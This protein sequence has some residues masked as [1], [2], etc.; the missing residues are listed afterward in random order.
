MTVSSPILHSKVLALV[1]DIILPICSLLPFLHHRTLDQKFA[2]LRRGPH[3]PYNTN[4]EA[5][6]DGAI[7]MAYG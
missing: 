1:N 3:Y 6:D 5:L 2:V 7:T 4:Q